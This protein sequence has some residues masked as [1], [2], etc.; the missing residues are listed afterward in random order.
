MEHDLG[1]LGSSSITCLLADRFN[2]ELVQ[3]K[4]DLVG[5]ATPGCVVSVPRS[6]FVFAPL[7]PP[8]LG[9]PVLRVCASP[10]RL[11][12]LK[13]SPDFSKDAHKFGEKTR[14]RASSPSLRRLAPASPSPC[15]SGCPR[16]DAEAAGF[17]ALPA[18]PSAPREPGARPDR[19][20]ICV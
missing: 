9:S 2:N 3:S 10:V 19:K 14:L 4:L 7:V 8:C 20:N 11:G 5:G 18:K 6:D 17:R 16:G 15:G 1:Y 13:F 12:T